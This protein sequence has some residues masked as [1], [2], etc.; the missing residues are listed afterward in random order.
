M[1]LD[2]TFH[3]SIHLGSALLLIFRNSFLAFLF[4]ILYICFVG[5]GK[6]GYVCNFFFSFDRNVHRQTSEETANANAATTTLHSHYN[7]HD[8]SDDLNGK[9]EHQDVTPQSRRNVQS[10]K[11]QLGVMRMGSR[12]YDL[13]PGTCAAIVVNLF[14][15]GLMI[16][17]KCLVLKFVLHYCCISIIHDFVAY[18]YKYVIYTICK[19]FFFFFFICEKPERFLPVHSWCLMH[20]FNVKTSISTTKC[21]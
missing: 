20:C 13:L 12:E 14:C 7:N 17:G 4:Y 19:V 18:I 21:F 9:E 2:S 1:C 3:R 6:L 5:K 16:C 11:E 8:S 15:M 10:G